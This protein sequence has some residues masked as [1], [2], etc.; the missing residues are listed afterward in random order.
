M[1]LAKSSKISKIDKYASE[2]LGI[3]LKDLMKRAGHAVAEAVRARVAPMSSVVIFAGKGNNGGDGYAAALELMSDYSVTVFDVFGKGQRTEEGK[4]FME[5]Y[6]R[7]GGE[8]R[9]L[10]LDDGDKKVIKSAACIID[11]IFGTG[12]KGEVPSEIK[13][14]SLIITEL[15]GIEKIAIDVPIGVNADDGSVDMA[16]A[17]TMTATVALSFIKPGLVSYPAK[18]YIGELIFDD[19]GLPIERITSHFRFDDHLVDRELA[20]SMMP[21]RQD[22]SNKGSFGRLLNITGCGRYRGAAHLSVEAS[23][24]GGVGRV[25]YIGE[26]ELV[27]A[28]SSKYPEVIYDR[29]ESIKNITDEEIEKIAD[30]STKESA[31]VIGS[32]SGHSAGLLKLVK[33]LLKSGDKP[34]ILDADAL[35]VLSDNSEEGRELIKNSTRPVVITPH[36]LEFSRISGASV[37]EIQLNR[38]SAAQSFAKDTGCVVVLKGAATVVTNGKRVYI[39]TSGSSALAKAGSGDVLAGLIGSVI[40]SGA[41]AL[42][43]SAM[44][45]YFHGAAADSLALELSAFG[46]TPSDLPK[47]IAREMAKAGR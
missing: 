37:S 46:V 14:L 22:N 25:T 3:P 15:V 4:H 31:T 2:K 13:T 44:S 36:P 28:L 47:E 45:V 17:C 26:G 18:A 41:D 23:L 42:T 7:G 33:A 10:K 5:A 20:V 24:R 38:I 39:N 8:L 19:I 12:F 34:L 40:A 43:A 29:V 11:A 32:G 16:S 30:L 9:A 21:K 27:K 1:I 35:N 6:A